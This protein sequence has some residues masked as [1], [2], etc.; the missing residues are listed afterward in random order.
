MKEVTRFFARLGKCKRAG[1]SLLFLELAQ[2]R[3][4][5]DL[6]NSGVLAFTYK[7]AFSSFPLSTKDKD[8]I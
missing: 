7:F 5:T 3:Q 4:Q 8:I 1:W 2:Q 6:S